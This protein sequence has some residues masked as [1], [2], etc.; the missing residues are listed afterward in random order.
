MA[1]R[2]ENV[3]KR[4]DGRWEGRILIDKGKYQ[5]L[6]GQSYKNVKDKM[7]DYQRGAKLRSEQESQ[8]HETAVWMLENW[9]GGDLCQQ[10]K[11]S[12][13]ETYYR[14]MHKYALPFFTIDGNSRMTKESVKRFAETIR[15]NDQLAESTKRKIL[16]IFRIAL[17]DILKEVPD[18]TSIMEAV[19]LPKSESR[20]IQVF[21]VKEQK[22][23]E[24]AAFRCEDKR[25]LGV[26]LCFYTGIRLGELC[27]L[28]W[29]D[30]DTDAGM[31]SVM[32]TVCRTKSF[33]PENA[34]KTELVVGTPKSRKSARKIPLPTFL[35][36]IVLTS[37]QFIPSDENAY[38]LSCKSTPVDPRS[39]QKL[40][41]RILEDAQLP[42]RKF[43]TIRHTFATRALEL[44]ID[45]KTVSE[46]LGHSNVST[47]LNIYAHSLMEHKKAAIEKFSQIHDASRAIQPFAV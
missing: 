9:L 5:Y 20:E 40:F 42:E 11:P 33:E 26:I 47:T 30:I 22:V 7:K 24:A 39:Y 23:L 1:R 8:R 25:A 28:R 3:Y 15:E 12:T 36:D 45:I 37:R 41:Q 35:M 17:K 2:G 6:Y 46:I 31:L 27:A 4:K 14:C 32:R 43:H 19:R 44:G 38:I 10:V 16:T 13:Y 34:K 21:S 18:H 29:S